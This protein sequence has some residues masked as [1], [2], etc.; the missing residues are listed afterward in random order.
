MHP[1][2]SGSPIAEEVPFFEKLSIR[3]P[4][5]E[6]IARTAVNLIRERDTIFL[7]PVRLALS[8]PVRCRAAAARHHKQH[9]RAEHAPDA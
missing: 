7:G 8:S 6:H 3:S 2:S 5:K 4:E 9:H 1:T